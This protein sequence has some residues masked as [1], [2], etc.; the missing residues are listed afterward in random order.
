MCC[1]VSPTTLCQLGTM[2]GRPNHVA[3]SASEVGAK[4]MSKIR[5]KLNGSILCDIS[6]FTLGEYCAAY[7]N[8][9]MIPFP[10][11]VPAASAAAQLLVSNPL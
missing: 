1:E 8:R 5:H 7:N 9:V 6:M 10:N 11:P 4:S 3:S 2:L